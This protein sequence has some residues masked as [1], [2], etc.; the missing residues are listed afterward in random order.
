MKALSIRQP[1]AWL[2]VHGFKPVENR[3]WPTKVRGP[4]AIHAGQQFDQAGLETLLAY[5][6]WLRQHLPQ[7]YDLGG[8]VGVAE[9]TDCVTQHHS[10]FFTGPYGHVMSSARPVPFIRYRGVLGYFDIPDE[11]L[12]GTLQA[13]AA[14]A[15]EV[16]QERLF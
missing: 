7:Q 2:I 9:L 16:G 4:V 10:P 3:T 11:L 12:A 6:P 14:E 13:S 15:E 5:M 1:W 8:I